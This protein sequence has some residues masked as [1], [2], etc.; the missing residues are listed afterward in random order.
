MGKPGP[1]RYF[2]Q[3]G[4]FSMH[5]KKCSYRTK[6]LEQWLWHMGDPA[7]V[8][9]Q[10]YAT[11]RPVCTAVRAQARTIRETVLLPIPVYRSI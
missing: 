10:S 11:F 9:R 6:L 3:D 2:M 7:A 5:I 8:H 4:D 1:S